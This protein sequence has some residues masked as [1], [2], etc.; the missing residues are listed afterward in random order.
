MELWTE[1]EGRTIDGSFPLA[2]LLQPEGRSAFFSTPNG[3]GTPTVIRLIESHFDDEEILARWRGVEALHHPNLLKLKKF[4]KTELDGTAL[5]YAVMEPAEA[6]LGEMVG[7]RRLTVPETTQIAT[8]LVAALDALHTNGFVH[9][10]VEPGNVLAV[11]EEIKLRSDCIREAPEGGEGRELKRRDVHDLAAVLL[12]ALTQQKT[13]EA[14]GELPLATP[15]DS[16]VRKGLSG[17][18]G[19]TEIGA[20]LVPVAAQRV[21]VQTAEPGV[22]PSGQRAP[23]PV[24]SP[25]PPTTRA[26]S[27]RAPL[28]SE[29]EDSGMGRGLMLLLGLSVLV[30]GLIAW[31]VFHGRPAEQGRVSPQGSVSAPASTSPA[32]TSSGATPVVGW[33]ANS[34]NAT[35][36]KK[37]SAAV[38]AGSAA[39]SR[40]VPERASVA[41][42]PVAPMEKVSTPIVKAPSA[43]ATGSV[44]WRAIAFTYNHEDQAKAKAAKVAAQHPELRPEVFSPSGNAPY[45]VTIGGAMGRDEA[46]ALARKARDEGLAH[47]VYAQNYRGGMV[48]PT[49]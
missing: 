21:D 31:Y 12:R 24:A 29:P 39:R 38:T 45:L 16:I 44:Q 27:F 1:Y 33:P 22:T 37:P 25:V 19:L 15:F 40:V 48:S 11:G 41:P 20:A 10:H 3:A 26:E 9:E 46:Y 32:S 17:E 23:L 13:L 47:D 35:L 6:N 30:L 18:W 8:S 34:A 4:G 28:R 14:A 43:K 5:V 7:E 2:K 42:V 36:G 49:H